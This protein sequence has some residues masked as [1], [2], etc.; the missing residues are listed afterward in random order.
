MKFIR[1]F[2]F[3]VISIFWVENFLFAGDKEKKGQC[4][5][6]CRSIR[7]NGLRGDHA[8]RDGIETGTDTN[9]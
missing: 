3:I 5:F 7:G 8:T 4:G 6:G 1:V 2:L 9:S